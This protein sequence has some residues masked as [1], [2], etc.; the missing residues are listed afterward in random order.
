MAVQTSPSVV[1]AQVVGAVKRESWYVGMVEEQ[2]W[3]LA[4]AEM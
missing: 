1:D 2:L 3:V 4:V